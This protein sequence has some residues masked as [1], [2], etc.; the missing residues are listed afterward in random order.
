MNFIFFSRL[1]REKG[2]DL[3]IEA[4]S[5]ISKDTGKLPGN[6]FIFSE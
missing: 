4:F 3:V 6:L 2:S 1:S 5:Q